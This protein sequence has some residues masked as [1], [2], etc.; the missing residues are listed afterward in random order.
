M[1]CQL[2][3]WK[4]E[5]L[6]I[7]YTFFDVIHELIYEN[8]P[9]VKE[10]LDN[11]PCNNE[12]VLDMLIEMKLNMSFS[13]ERLNVLLHSDTFLYKLSWKFKFREVSEDSQKTL[14]YHYLY[15]YDEFFGSYE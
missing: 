15:H 6:S 9:I 10:Q 8:T 4:K 1:D 11:L 12:Q 13:K 14:Y 3:Y 2:A 5:I 7:E